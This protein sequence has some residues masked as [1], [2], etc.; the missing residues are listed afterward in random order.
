[1]VWLCKTKLWWKS[2]I[3][4]YGYRQYYNTISLSPHKQV[5]LI[6][7][8]SPIIGSKVTVLWTLNRKAKIFLCMDT[9]SLIEYNKTDDIYKDI[10]NII[11]NRF[12]TLSYEWDRLT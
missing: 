4:L 3:V 11:K 6:R 2:K 7:D 10:S 8:T 12:V 5:L 9:D 1:M